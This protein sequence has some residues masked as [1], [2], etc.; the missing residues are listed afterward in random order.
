MAEDARAFVGRSPQGNAELTFR[1]ARPTDLW[2]HARGVPG[3][4][5]ILRVDGGRH[6]TEREIERAAGLAAHYSKA[7]DAAKVDVDFTERKYV[8]KQRAAAPGL[9]WYSDSRTL[10]VAPSAD[11]EDGLAP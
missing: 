8:R 11:E 6:P 9:V 5:V 7:R 3:A 2:F 1:M 10:R 4:H